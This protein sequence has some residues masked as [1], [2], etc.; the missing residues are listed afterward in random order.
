[1]RCKSVKY[2]KKQN[3]SETIR[4]KIKSFDIFEN[5]KDLYRNYVKLYKQLQK[6]PNNFKFTPLVSVDKENSVDKESNNQVIFA[7]VV[8][9]VSKQFHEKI[10]L[11]PEK[12][13]NDFINGYNS[14]ENLL[15]LQNVQ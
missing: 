6:N 3:V 8:G 9:S 11:N 13:F 4:K 15:I 10:K 7:A 12:Q 2:K 5:I 1:M 14:K